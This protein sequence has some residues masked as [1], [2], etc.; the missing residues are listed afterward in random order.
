[1]LENEGISVKQYATYGC[2]DW[3]TEAFEPKLNT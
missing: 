2:P 3:L 1:M